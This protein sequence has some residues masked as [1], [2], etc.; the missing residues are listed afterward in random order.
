MNPKPIKR[1]TE[2]QGVSRDHHH[3]LLLVWKINKGI[4]NKIEPKRIINYIGWFRKEHLEPHFAV[5]EEFMFPVL[6]NEHPKVQQALHEHIQLLSQAKN[7]ENYKD[8]ESFAK[9]LKNHIR[10]EER[11]LFQLIQ[12]KATQEELDLIEKK[13]QDEKFCERTEDEFWK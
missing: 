3:A 6:G 12:E 9:L 1:K 13:H 5:E 11:D 2:L 7:A 4:S 10:F 8:L